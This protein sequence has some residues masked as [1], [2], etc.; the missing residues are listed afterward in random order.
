VPGHAQARSILLTRLERGAA[1]APDQRLLDGVVT[2][3]ARLPLALSIVAARV[4]TDPRGSLEAIGRELVEH[5]RLDALAGDETGVDVRRIFSWSYH[6][7]SPATQRLFLLFALLPGLDV[8]GPSLASLAGMP[9][10]DLRG[11]LEELVRAQLVT[12]T[13]QRRYTMHDLLRAYAVELAESDLTADERGA[14]NRRLLDHLVHSAVAASALLSSYRKQPDPGTPAEGVVPEM[15]DGLEAATAWFAAEH[16][17]LLA[18]VKDACR[19]GTEHAWRLAWAL[20]PFLEHQGLWHDWQAIQQQT[21]QAAADRGDVPGQAHGYESLGDAA[22][23]L[24]EF[25]AAAEH[26]A[27]ASELYRR[28]GAVV[29]QARVHLGQALLAGCQEQY[30]FSLAEAQRALV[31]FVQIGHRTG[32]ANALN[33]IGWTRVQLGLYAGALA[34]CRRALLLHQS[35]SNVHGE[36]ATLDSLGVVHDGLGNHAAALN[37][38][39][40]ALDFYRRV[41]HRGLEAEVLAHIGDSHASALDIEAANEAWRSALRIFDDLDHS[42]ADEIRA[43]LTNA[44]PA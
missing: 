12:E 23:W 2:A 13:P 30:E 19:S 29:G 7:L 39:G 37:C 10:V 41:G 26:Y 42:D 31:L 40:S 15:F 20:G 24:T 32:E 22:T 4:A 44:Q 16:L 8:G 17:T 36:A 33:V 3:C 34:A 5:P 25:D 9:T 38:V 28:T 14:A 21:L 18:A 6:A 27:R 1:R 35:L 11:L 43:K